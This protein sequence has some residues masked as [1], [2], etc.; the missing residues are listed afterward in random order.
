M[1]QPSGYEQGNK[2]CLLNKSVYGLKKLRRQWYRRFDEYMLINGFKGSSYDRC[3]YYRSYALGEYIYILL[4]L[5]DMLIACKSKAEIG[6]TKSL[7]KKKFDM[8]ELGEAKKILGMEIVRDKSRKILRVS[9]S[10][11]V[12]KILNNFRIDNGKL[13]KM[14]LGGHFKLSLKDCPVRDCDVERMSKVLYANAVGILMYLMVCTRPDIAYAVSVVSK[15]LA[16]LGSIILCAAACYISAAK[17]VTYCCQEGMLL[18]GVKD[19]CYKERRYGRDKVLLVYI[20]LSEKEF[21]PLVLSDKAVCTASFVRYRTMTLKITCSCLIDG[22]EDLTNLA[23]VCDFSYGAQCSHLLSLSM[24]LIEDED[25]VKRFIFLIVCNGGQFEYWKAGLVVALIMCGDIVKDSNSYLKSRG[26][27][28]D[29]VS[30][31]EMITS[32]LQGKLWLYDENNMLQRRTSA[33]TTRAA[34]AT[35][36]ADA[37]AAATAPMTAA[38]IEQLIEARVSVGLANHETL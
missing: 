31:R 8:K 25:F 20:V 22:D 32:Q 24:C 33:A 28:E 16:N 13:V 19:I 29:F 34:A 35:A 17:E 30:F 10:W 23:K 7:L 6:S 36:R 2:V 9:Q 1:S 15:Y 4:Y 3:V 21:I 37:A 27:I 11:Y 26:S 5:D 14:P 18:Y 38:A 12:S